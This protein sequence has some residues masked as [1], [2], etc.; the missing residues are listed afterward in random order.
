M[1]ES[2][3]QTARRGSGH[4]I[5]QAITLADGPL[6]DA[7]SRLRTST[8]YGTFDS[9]ARYDAGRT[10]WESIL[11]GAGANTAFVDN[12][13]AVQLNVGT[14]DGEYAIEQTYRYFTYVPGKSQLIVMTGLMGAGKTNVVRRMGYFDNEDGLFFEVNGAALRLVNRTSTSGTPV[15]N[16]YEQADWNLDTMDGTESIFNVSGIKLDVSNVQILVIDFQWLGAGRVRFGFDINGRTHYV[17]EIYNANLVSIV[18]MKRPNLPCRYEIRNVGVSASPS[19]L[20][21]LCSS[22]V[23]EAG[24]S[25]P[26]YQF[27]ED[28]GSAFRTIGTTVTPVF[29][30]RMKQTHG[31]ILTENRESAQ[32][33]QWEMNTDGAGYWQLWVAYN[34]TTVTGTWADVDTDHSV[35]EYS[36]NISVISGG[37]IHK[38]D[39]GYITSAGGP[40]GGVVQVNASIVSQH[41]FLHRNYANDGGNIIYLAYAA[42]AVTDDVRGQLAWL[43]F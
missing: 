24:Y 38:M 22:V 32:I 17:H 8:P 36:R 11:N 23:N 7:F 33:V 2:V 39:S 40:T 3:S 25:L 5:S 1:Q 15:D 30:I 13:S 10:T 37:A 34:P 21:R 35:V 42:D 29:A 41:N 18:Y 20:R 16:I 4:R 31:G 19:T 43:E 27:S 9:S 26:G 12:E 14:V 28:S 6:T